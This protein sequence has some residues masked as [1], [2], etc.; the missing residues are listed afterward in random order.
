MTS[1]YFSCPSSYLRSRV[2]ED[3]DH[4]LICFEGFQEKIQQS[5]SC[6]GLLL[7]FSLAL[8]QIYLG[9]KPF[10]CHTGMLSIGLLWFRPSTLLHTLIGCAF[11]S[12]A[13]Q[14]LHWVHTLMVVVASVGKRMHMVEE[15]STM[16]Y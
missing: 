10:L 12:A 2:T 6:T 8:T 4:Y 14:A 1:F 16:R 9:F 13:T 5:M 7:R 15:L 3:L 11:E